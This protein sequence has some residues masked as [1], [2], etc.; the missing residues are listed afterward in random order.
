MALYRAPMIP[1]PAGMIAGALVKLGVTAALGPVAGWAA[2]G[3]ALASLP[4]TGKVSAWEAAT[5]G[6]VARHGARAARAVSA[7]LARLAPGCR[8]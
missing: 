5:V 7:A 8:A 2:I 4:L 3:V 6:V 1:T